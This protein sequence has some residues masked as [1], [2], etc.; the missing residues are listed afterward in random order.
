MGYD[1]DCSGRDRKLQCHSLSTWR[2]S[3]EKMVTWRPWGHSQP[4]DWGA[5]MLFSL[6]IASLHLPMCSVVKKAVSNKVL[7][8][9]LLKVWGYTPLYEQGYSFPSETV[10]SE[11]LSPFLCIS[12][13]TPLVLITDS[14]GTAA[15]FHQPFYVCPGNSLCALEHPAWPTNLDIIS[16][17][18][19]HVLISRPGNIYLISWDNCRKEQSWH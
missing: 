18:L 16:P 12:I 15:S 2:S 6:L 7:T 9:V 13:K 17:W 14:E 5:E 3:W 4:T 1:A 19:H 8:W 10:R 11:W